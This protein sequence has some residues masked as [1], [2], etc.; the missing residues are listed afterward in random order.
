MRIAEGMIDMQN[1]AQGIGHRWPRDWSL[2]TDGFGRNPSDKLLR[3]TLVQ[4]PW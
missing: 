4:I 2:N 3:S 1:D